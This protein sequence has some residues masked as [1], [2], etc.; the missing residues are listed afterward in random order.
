MITIS[1]PKHGWSTLT[2]PCENETCNISLSYIQNIPFYFLDTFINYLNDVNNTDD[3]MIL[4]ID[5]EGNTKK[6]IVDAY[7]TY[8]IDEASKHLYVSEMD[9]LQFMRECIEEFEKNI[10]KWS[11]FCIFEKIE[12]NYETIKMQ[13]RIFMKG[14]IEIIRKKIG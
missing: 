12:K 6:I 7:R 11:E 2:I 3:T 4:N 13:N 9:F 14:K 5:E 1:K 10:E 8:I